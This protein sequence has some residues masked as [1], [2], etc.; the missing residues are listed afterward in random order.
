MI[1]VFHLFH[2]QENVS[3][4]NNEMQINKGKMKLD[5]IQK[6]LLFG[7]NLYKTNSIERKNMGMQRK[8]VAFLLIF[9]F[10]ILWQHG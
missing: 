9:F 10:I 6:K 2:H 7:I 3:N 1:F 5:N 4:I 8:R